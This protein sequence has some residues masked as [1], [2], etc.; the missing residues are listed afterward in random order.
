MTDV[1]GVRDY[2]RNGENGFFVTTD[3]GDIAA[4]VRLI[5]DDR[6]R[7]ANMAEAARTSVA[8]SDWS[9]IARD[10]AALIE[11]VAAERAFER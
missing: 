6:V 10:Y 5:A 11:S 2:L 1:G 7:L 8:G 4:K 9:V 3:A